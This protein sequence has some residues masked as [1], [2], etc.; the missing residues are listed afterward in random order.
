MEL[1]TDNDSDDDQIA[2][3]RSR[4]GRTNHNSNSNQRSHITPQSPQDEEN[5]F[6]YSL[7]IDRVL[8]I[9]NKSTENELKSLRGIGAAKARDIMMHRPFA[10]VCNTIYD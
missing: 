10:T 4:R 2:S 7:K 3:N 5:A 9:V 6:S 1:S 8:N